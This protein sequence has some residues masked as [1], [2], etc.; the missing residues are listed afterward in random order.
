M[1][2]DVFVGIDVGKTIFHAAV[3]DGAAVPREWASLPNAEFEH[4]LPGVTAFLAWL[5][6]L[7][8]TRDH[9]AGVCLEAT[10]RYGIR[11]AQ[12]LQDRLAPVCL[13]NPARPKAYG[14]SVGIRDKT[15]RVDACVLAL[16]AKAT[17]PRPTRPDSPAQVELRELSRLHHAIE[18]QCHANRQRLADGP[19]SAFVQA[20]L[21]KTIA[22]LERQMKRI[23]Q[24]LNK[25][26]GQDETLGAD[27]KRAQSVP[28]IG[29]K[30]ATLLLA[31]FGNLR[32]YNRDELVALAGLYPRQY[33]SGTSVHKR[34]R[35]AKAGK[36]R[37][38]AAL[39]MCAM[40][41][42]RANRAVGTFVQR[43]KDRGKRPMQILGAVMRKLLLL[44]HAVV[45]SDTD[46]DPDYPQQV[47]SKMT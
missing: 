36:A 9:V 44:V 28:G 30:T 1:S 8:Y 17:R 25:L 32:E 22:A 16:F 34:P 20:T 3:A 38:R 40:S 6:G 27:C 18:Q 14:V 39:Y 7:G 33:T 13:V 29:A 47:Q 41:A 43:L 45:V 37:V 35:L 31:E 23:E 10:G 19:A 2:Q 26:I 46:Y 15:D 42:M 4:S 21:K 5:G 24:A 11:W 12:A